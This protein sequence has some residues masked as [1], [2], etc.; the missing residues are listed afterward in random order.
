MRH[1]GT[2]LDLAEGDS[3]DGDVLSHQWRSDNGAITVQRREPAGGRELDR[4]ECLD[5]RVVAYLRIDD[6]TGASCTPFQ[7]TAV[8]SLLGKGTFVGRNDHFVAIP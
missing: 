7:R 8:A 6:G 4:I 3:A 2:R 5:V 1:V